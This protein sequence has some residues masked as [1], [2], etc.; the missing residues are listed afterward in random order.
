MGIQWMGSAIY[1]TDITPRYSSKHVH[2]RCMSIPPL[3][4]K[5]TRELEVEHLRA[6]TVRLTAEIAEV[7]AARKRQA[8]EAVKKSRPTAI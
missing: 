3:K 8:S 2:P 1:R 7:R 4:T 5:S 6:E